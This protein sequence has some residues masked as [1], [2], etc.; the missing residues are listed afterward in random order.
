MRHLAA[1]LSEE[2]DRSHEA[3]LV[4]FKRPLG[5]RLGT[6]VLAVNPLHILR[7]RFSLDRAHV[8][9]VRQAGSR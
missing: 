9:F 7:L 6:V 3:I 8:P 1:T 5:D 2:I 4:W